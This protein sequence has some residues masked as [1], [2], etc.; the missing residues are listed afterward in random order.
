MYKWLSLQ[1]IHD[2]ST[3]DVIVI[4]IVEISIK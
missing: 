2:Y 1:I 3:F 4:C